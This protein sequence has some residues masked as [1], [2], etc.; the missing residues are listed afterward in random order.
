M[1]DPPLLQ[2]ALG[3]RAA[4]T[5]QLRSTSGSPTRQRHTDD[6]LLRLAPRTAVDALRNPS[7]EL[8]R[9]LDSASPSEQA[10]AMR[11]AVASK[12]IQEWLEELS[13]WPWPTHDTSAGFE[14]PPAK[15]RKLF[16]RS[17]SDTGLEGLEEEASEKTLGSL[18]ASDVA[19]YERR[20]H[21]IGQDMED[22]NVEEIKNHILHNHIMPLSRPGTPMSDSLRASTLSLSAYAH[23]DDFTALITA[24]IV[25]ALPNLSKLTRL[26]NTWSIR[27]VVLRKSSS[28]LTA[29]MDAEIALKAG[30]KAMGPR[31]DMECGDSESANEKR[32]TG[33][34]LSRSEFDIMKLVVER[35]VAKAGQ[36]LDFMLD[37]MEGREDT[38]PEDWI[39]RM[40]TVEQQY[41]E[42]AAACERQIR[43]AEWAKIALETR[44]ARESLS[45]DVTEEATFTSVP[46]QEASSTVEE[47]GADATF[48]SATAL[49][50][51]QSRNDTLNSLVATDPTTLTRGPYRDHVS[52]TKNGDALV[53]TSDA[54]TGNSPPLI[55]V[56]PAAEDITVFGGSE[57]EKRGDALPVIMPERQNAE[58]TLTTELHQLPDKR[59]GSEVSNASTVIHGLQSGFAG[60]SSDPPDHGTPD[61]QR[62]RD[63][64]LPSTE[65]DD[66]DLIDDADLP[67]SPPDFRSSTRSL[68]VSFN[69]IPTVVE[70]PEEEE[71][72]PDTP[73]DA[74]FAV[75]DD[76]VEE[77]GLHGNPSK[78]SVGSADDQ[79]QQQI[80]EI[81]DSIPAK[82]R[83]TSE[84]SAI[85]LNPP[86]FSMPTSRPKGKH[87][88]FP[89]RSYSSLSNRSSR[90]GTPSFTLAP[91][92]NS[93]PRH[94]RG[95]QE[96]K[97]YHLSRSNGEP[98]IKLFI[99]CVGDNGERVMVR[100]GGGWADLGEYLKEY[101]SHHGCRGGEAKVE[102]RDLPRITTASRAGS[103]PPSRPASAMDMSSPPLPKTPLANTAT[104]DNN[105][106]ESS[107]SSRSRSSSRLSWTEEDSSLGMAG[108][109][110]KHI[111]M[112]EENKAWV[113]SVKE[114]VRIASGDQRAALAKSP[115]VTGATTPDPKLLPDGKFG[116]LGKVGATK[117]LFR[118]QAG[119]GTGTGLGL[120][121]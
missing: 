8:K 89:P 1:N 47:R 3:H 61:Y 19:R 110:S 46:S 54:E 43:E 95:N 91:A 85:N 42:W 58:E 21:E 5:S 41:A 72:P 80:S 92:K 34:A 51:T 121:K 14:R 18:L 16:A 52:D 30:W 93:R 68:S 9:C 82:I 98:P 33:S 26:L 55:M 112:S 106:P 28:F 79:L 108:P 63:A 65:G 48:E 6:L 64:V 117:R 11:V 78:M 100:V 39:D 119:P 103:S 36:Y 97:L 107:G 90:A 70:A 24:T 37:A 111:E 114:K 116:E 29:L 49:G 10:F 31:L 94:Q 105:T 17:A 27:L 66:V 44:T 56:H 12:N 74:S 57:Q 73:L 7:G 86:D 113:E 118:R 71:T 60:F 88:S 4:R 102:V 77:V 32:T 50:N 62:F 81:L 87:D 120:G 69:D 35:K 75:E 23:M 84:P 40:D 22:L 15:R 104:A 96:I 20:I 59:R 38:L 25:Q 2:P 76:P 99:R 115:A 45:T 101:A 83:L 67:S 53:A 13:T 109:K